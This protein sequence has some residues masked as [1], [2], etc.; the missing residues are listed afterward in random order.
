M[1]RVPFFSLWLLCAAAV[2]AQ[3]FLVSSESTHSVKRYDAF[4]GVYLGDFVTPGSGGL[5]GPQ[6]IA[7][8]PDGNIY[9]SSRD[10]DNVLRYN[11]T[12]GAFMGVFA[13]LP[14][15]AFPADL[16]FR[17]GHLYVSNFNGAG[18]Y[19][20]RFD[21]MTGAFV[22]KFITNILGPDG[23]SWDTAGN[24]YVSSF[25]LGKV[26]KFNGT[27]GAF[28]SDFVPA[29]F[30][31]LGGPLDNRFEPNGDFLVSSFNTGTVK[32][33][34][35]T[36]AYLG[37]FVS[38]GGATQGIEVGPDGNLYVGD[39]QNSM[40]KKYNRATGALL[41]VFASGGGL[42]QP[43][44]FLFRIPLHQ[45]SS[46]S[47]APSGVVSGNPGLGRIELSTPAPA[48]GTTITLTDNSAALVTPPSLLIPEGQ[49]VGTFQ[50]QTL[51]TS[52]QIMR[53]VKAQLGSQIITRN[54]IV[55]L[56][57]ITTMTATPTTVIGGN[58]VNVTI[59][60]NGTVGNGFTV[61]LAASGPEIVPPAS[62]T[63]TYASR[64]NTF[65]MPTLDVTASRVR[66]L[67]ATRN[68]R[69]RTVTITVLN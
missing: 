56:P 25:G 14:D 34:S 21:A 31:G 28:I 48:G 42:Q 40:I 37:D 2:T 61:T 55:M 59:N 12:T 19:V 63:F 60:A 58:P 11:K 26:S 27:T 44:N 69:T 50:I 53:Q 6:G 7:V 39:Y 13:S 51:S 49:T 24:L 41:G 57:D 9:V 3:D 10:S 1:N 5:G 8:G 32:R 65:S 4:T 64:F 36:G 22:D 33:Y 30:G 18:S 43:N 23:L 29:G 52:V 66:V 16:A 46:Y 62:V 17:G 35:S 68:G 47:I 67:T 38:V 15:L 45:I 20:A 54:L